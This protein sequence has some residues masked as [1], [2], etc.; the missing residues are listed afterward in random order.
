MEII[1]VLI[2]SVIIVLSVSKEINKSKTPISDIFIKVAIL[3]ISTVL[4]TAIVNSFYVVLFENIELTAVNII[5]RLSFILSLIG[6]LCL[7]SNNLKD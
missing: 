4:I 5:I 7:K 1:N 6:V 2:F 3:I